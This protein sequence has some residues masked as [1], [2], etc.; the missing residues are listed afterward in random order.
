M[1]GNLNFTCVD[2]ETTGLNPKHDR[3]IEIGFVKVRNGKTADTYTCL[4]DPRQKL[5]ESIEQITGISSKD[6]EGKPF[7]SDVIG[8]IK[9]FLEDDILVGHRILFDYSFLKRA[10]LNAG[11]SFER[12]G[13]DTLFLAR[14]LVEDCEKKSLTALCNHYGI[15]YKAHRALSDAE[16]TVQL[17]DLLTEKYYDENK[18]LFEPKELLFK[19]K[20]EGPITKPQKEQII[21]LM[22][23][24]NLI[25]QKDISS[26]TKNE[27]SRYI[28]QILSTYG[29]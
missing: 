11:M 13:I 21:R 7:F 1:K 18:V 5:E 16:A 9:E 22:E 3:I 8:V 14:K 2:L 4:L 24:H 23:K 28:D 6:L 26:L 27:A 29:R 17:Y 10:F 12:K 19:I 15:I 25:P 20:K